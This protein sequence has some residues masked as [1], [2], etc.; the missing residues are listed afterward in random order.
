MNEFSPTRPCG[1]CG[2]QQRYHNPPSAWSGSKG[3][4]WGNAR[5]N[6]TKAMTCCDSC[7]HCI[8]FCSGFLEPFI[9]MPFERCLYETKNHAHD[10]HNEW[11][12]SSSVT[13]PSMVSRLS[14]GIHDDSRVTKTR[15]GKTQPAPKFRKDHR[16]GRGGNLFR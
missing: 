10:S 16:K 12:L 2:C 1:R 3:Y 9:G 14:T 4:S 5:W 15:Q 11:N 8:C 6:K 7:P 13:V